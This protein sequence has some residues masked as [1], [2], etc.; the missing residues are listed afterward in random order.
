MLGLAKPVINRK[1]PSKLFPSLLYRAKTLAS[2]D[3]LF[4]I[5]AMP[6]YSLASYASL[7][8]GI[9]TEDKFQVYIILHV[10]QPILHLP[11]PTLHLK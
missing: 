3:S 1:A 2:Y 5:S 9:A 10:P 4:P 8:P 11:Q 7:L 6:A